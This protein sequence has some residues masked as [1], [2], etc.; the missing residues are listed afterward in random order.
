MSKS[1]ADKRTTV[2]GRPKPALGLQW[3]CE[4]AAEGSSLFPGSQGW[5]EGWGLLGLLEGGSQARLTPPL[6]AG[7]LIAALN[8]AWAPS[9]PLGRRDGG[10]LEGKGLSPSH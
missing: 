10:T 1:Q 6:G 2:V 3:S 7:T 9:P 4:L 5:K 8:S